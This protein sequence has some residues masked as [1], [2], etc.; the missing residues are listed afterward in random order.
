VAYAATPRV[1]RNNTSM[2]VAFSMIKPRLKSNN[3]VMFGYNGFFEAEMMV[4]IQ[5]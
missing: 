5:V 4:I 2:S 1:T 3:A